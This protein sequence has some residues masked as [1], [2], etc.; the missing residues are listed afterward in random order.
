MLTNQEVAA[1]R[2]IDLDH[3]DVRNRA[4]ALVRQLRDTHQDEL[5]R[6]LNDAI[7]LEGEHITTLVNLTNG[8]QPGV[9]DQAD[10]EDADETRREV[11]QEWSRG[12]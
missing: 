6:P 8:K 11:W 9:P 7:A 12:R 10:I 2:A 5:M 4:M 3:N 1:I